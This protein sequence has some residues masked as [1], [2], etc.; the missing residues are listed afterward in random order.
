MERAIRV[1]FYETTREMTFNADEIKYIQS[2]YNIQLIES[3]Y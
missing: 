1:P 3:L 2:N